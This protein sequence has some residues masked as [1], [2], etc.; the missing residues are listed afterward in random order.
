MVLIQQRP[1]SLFDDTLQ[2]IVRDSRQFQGGE[3]PVVTGRDSLFKTVSRV[4]ADESRLHV[5]PISPLREDEHRQA[6]E[7]VHQICQIAE[8]TVTL[9]LFGG[10]A[11][12]DLQSVEHEHDGPADEDE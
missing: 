5:L 8:E 12:Q 6:P 9:C 7:P 1:H 2:V 10:I 4:A 11:K 3:R